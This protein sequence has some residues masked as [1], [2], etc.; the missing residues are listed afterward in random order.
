[1]QHG[2]TSLDLLSH[3][4]RAKT[5]ESPD[6][7]WVDEV[8]PEESPKILIDYFAPSAPLSEES[9]ELPRSPKRG[10]RWVLQ[11]TAALAVLVYAAS[12]LTEFAYLLAAEHT[13]ALAARAGVME[14]TLPR[15]TYQ[16]VTATIERHLTGY[17]RLV[18]QMHVSLLQNGSLVQRQLSQNDGD[19]FAIMLWA[20]NN[21]VVPDWLRVFTVWHNDARIQAHAEH[22]VPGRKLPAPSATHTAAE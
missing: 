7:E 16:S 9:I 4:D 22:R 11:W 21:S 20:P 19:R 8:I 6:F 14:A 18:K 10:I 5:V 17:P 3:F 13:M 2:Q 1:M 12:V 15:A